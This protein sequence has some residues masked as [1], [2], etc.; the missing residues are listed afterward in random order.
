MIPDRPSQPHPETPRRTEVSKKTREKL[1]DWARDLT[2][3]EEHLLL[4]V[5]D[6]DIQLTAGRGNPSEG[7]DFMISC[8]EPSTEFTTRHTF[9]MIGPD[10]VA[11]TESTTVDPTA[12]DTLDETDETFHGDSPVLDQEARARHVLGLLAKGEV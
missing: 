10:S 12:T 9:L 6:E 2:S 11:L 5:A 1:R 4:H 3:R 7:W 8:H